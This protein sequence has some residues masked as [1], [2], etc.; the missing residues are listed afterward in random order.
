[1]N[2]VSAASELAAPNG[3][4]CAAIGMFDGVH[5]GHQQVI[6]QAITDAHQLEATS[7]CI[8]FDRHPATVIAPER[9][10]GLIQ[11]LFQRLHA[12]ETL[13]V[14]STLLLKFD[15]P[16]SRIAAPDFIR[17]LNSGTVNIP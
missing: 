5:L 6:R 2:I 11:S 9:A 14:D 10:P 12:I 1:M 4:V 15:E 7:L 16:M 17:D 3:R 8:T 13:G